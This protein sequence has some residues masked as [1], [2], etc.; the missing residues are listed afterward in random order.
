[1]VQS[2]SAFGCSSKSIGGCNIKFHRFPKDPVLQRKWVNATKRKN[3]KPSKTSVLCQKHFL[4]S[5]YKETVMETKVLKKEA[6]PSLFN[7]PAKLINTS[8]PTTKPRRVL[9]RKRQDEE[10][11]CLLPLAKQ[12]AEVCN[13]NINND[14]PEQASTQYSPN[15]FDITTSKPDNK[16]IQTTA[17][18]K[19]VLLKTQTV[20]EVKKSSHRKRIRVE[21]VFLGDFRE[22]DLECPIKRKR[23]WMQTQDK[24]KMLS[25]KTKILQ[26]CLKRRESKIAGMNSLVDHLRKQNHLTSNESFFLKVGKI[27]VYLFY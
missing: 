7:F 15:Q 19:E 23:Y 11:T 2:C 22:K 4:E 26:A 6:V 16:V 17:G 27:L 9:I 18:E 13:S 14:E 1:M 10:D 3:F 12:V 24:L 20:L 8:T 5:D 21:P 25:R